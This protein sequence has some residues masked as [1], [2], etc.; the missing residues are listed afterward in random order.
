[1][2]IFFNSFFGWSRKEQIVQ[3]SSTAVG[4]VLKEKTVRFKV[5]VSFSILLPH[6][7]YSLLQASYDFQFHRMMLLAIL[8]VFINSRIHPKFQITGLFTILSTQGSICVPIDLH[9]LAFLHML[10]SILNILRRQNTDGGTKFNAI[11]TNFGIV[12]SGQ[13][14]VQCNLPK[15]K[16]S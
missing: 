16:V 13:F 4:F 11:R 14:L 2:V 15:K 5:S 12:F 7:F 9:N 10:Q 8:Q 1:M 3:I 6:I